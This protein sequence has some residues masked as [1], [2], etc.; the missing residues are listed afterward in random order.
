[1]FYVTRN[2]SGIIHT[3]S[4]LEQPGSEM[5]EENHPEIKQFLSGDLNSVFAA[6]DTEFFRVLE[7]L[8]DTL[9]EKNIIHHTD[10]PVAAQQKLLVR[11]DIRQ[12]VQ[13]GLQL[14]GNDD[15]IPL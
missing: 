13:V 15:P 1:M 2:S 11:K 5:L 12:H 10:L 3:I 8:I 14:L 6:L 7:D 9:I 4:K